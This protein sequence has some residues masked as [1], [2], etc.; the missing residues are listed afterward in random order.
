M[1]DP[2]TTRIGRCDNLP[3]GESFQSD[4]EFEGVM[5]PGFA[6]GASSRIVIGEQDQA[7][8]VP[9]RKRHLPATG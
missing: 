8:T 9:Y 6:S 1:S 5:G 4:L 2:D 7:Q 3:G